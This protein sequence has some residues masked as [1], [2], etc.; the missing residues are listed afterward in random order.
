MHIVIPESILP[1]AIEKLTLEHSVHYDPDLV[2]K[3][4]ELL[5]AVE[6]ADALIVRRLTQVK[7]ELLSA[8]PRCKVVGRL[9]VGLDNIDTLTC[10]ARGIA[11]IPALGANARSVA[12]YVIAAAMMLLRGAYH[13]TEEVVDGAWPKER[14]N[15]GREVAGK[16]LGVVGFG[17][18]G[19]VTAELAEAV[20]MQVVVHDV[21]DSNDPVGVR[22]RRLSLESLLACSDVVT[23]HVPLTE[24]TRALMDTARIRG[25]KPGAVLINAARGG[26][27]DDEALVAALRTGHLGGAAIDAFERE[28]LVASPQY[29]GLKNLILTPH[30]AGVT[31]ESEARVTELVV[32]RVLE[33]LRELA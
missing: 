31:R 27:V 7:G 30:I 18:I 4:D 3:P 26:I 6:T 9:G 15:L 20:G 33:V 29:R 11:V 28:P 2:G 13:S 10:S 17:S 8:M 16:T 25:M 23:L 21:S 24:Q 12:E 32:D 14:L 19:R 1:N 22:Y 5:R